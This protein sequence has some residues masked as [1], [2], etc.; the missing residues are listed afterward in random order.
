[1]RGT[2]TIDQAE[3]LK[4]KIVFASEI[5]SI[6]SGPNANANLLDMTVFVSISRAIT[7]DYWLPKVYGESARPLLE[8]FIRG[9]NEIW[10]LA[11]T[12]LT[13]EQRTELR[14]AIVTWHQKHPIPQ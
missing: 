7:E 14:E 13:P 6:A 5:S 9:E 12:I 4:W 1:R 10:E 3:V 8:A 2:N 11:A